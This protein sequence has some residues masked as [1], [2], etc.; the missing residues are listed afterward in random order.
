MESSHLIDTVLL[1]A[2]KLDLD[3]KS[4]FESRLCS[5]LISRETFQHQD[6]YPE[7]H[8]NSQTKST[9]FKGSW[10]EF[11]S[12]RRVYFDLFSKYFEK[13]SI[14]KDETDK[15]YLKFKESKQLER[16]IKNYRGEKEGLLDSNEDNKHPIWYQVDYL[17]TWKSERKNIRS[18]V[19]ALAK[20]KN[21]QIFQ[22]GFI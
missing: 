20:T 4:L 8:W 22:T 16:A 7:F 6:Q 11:I 19:E 21:M 1:K 5:M 10:G 9:E 13:D 14:I 17:M 2:M 18:F 12:G 15:S 3:L